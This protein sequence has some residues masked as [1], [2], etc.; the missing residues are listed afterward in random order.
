MGY[1]SDLPNELVSQIW[2]CVESPEDIVSFGQV[3]K[4]IY[5]QGGEALQGHRELMKQYSVLHSKI[6]SRSLP[7]KWLKDMLIQPRIALYI[8]QL[9]IAGW[10]EEWDPL[11]DSHANSNHHL[12]SPEDVYLFKQALTDSRLALSEM[13]SLNGW[14][15]LSRATKIPSLR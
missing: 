3:S 6:E 2:S 11:D 8:K 13:K 14:K 12:L 1:F 5:A 9:V 10:R 4:G 7:A 15:L